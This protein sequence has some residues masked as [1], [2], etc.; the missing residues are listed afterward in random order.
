[1]KKVLIGIGIFTL[2]VIIIDIVLLITGTPTISKTILTYTFKYNWQIFPFFIGVLVGH[3]FL[4][5]P[6]SIFKMWFGIICLIV[7][8]VIIQLIS[9]FLI[10][11]TPIITVIIGVCFGCLFWAQ[12]LKK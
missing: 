5:L 8:Y 1:M 6:K 3:F 9:S 7:C 2:L 12:S 4:P 10:F 11:I